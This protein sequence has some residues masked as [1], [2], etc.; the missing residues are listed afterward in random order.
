MGALVLSRFVEGP[1]LV[2][3]AAGVE[4]AQAKNRLGSLQ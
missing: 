4:G 1:V 2:E 3:V